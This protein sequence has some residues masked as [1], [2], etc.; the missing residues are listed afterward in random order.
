MALSVGNDIIPSF[1][2]TQEMNPGVNLADFFKDGTL[3]YGEVQRIV[4][5]DDPASYSKKFI[6]YDVYVQLQENNTG[7][8]K[9][10]SGATLFNLFGGLADKLYWSLRPSNS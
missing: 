7:V 4:Y 9:M 8:G 1:L 10:Y 6:E 2:E 5:P 3:H